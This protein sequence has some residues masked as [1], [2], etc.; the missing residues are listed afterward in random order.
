M[1]TSP[2]FIKLTASC[3]RIRAKYLATSLDELIQHDVEDFEKKKESGDP[4]VI[5]EEADETGNI[6]TTTTTTTTIIEKVVV[7]GS[8]ASRSPVITVD[9]SGP[10]VDVPTETTT[11]TTTSTNGAST[12]AAP[13]DPSDDP[14]VPDTVAEGPKNRRT[15]CEEKNDDDKEEMKGKILVDHDDPNAVYIGLRVYTHKDVPAVIVGRLKTPAVSST[16]P[17]AVAAPTT[18]V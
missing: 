13:N 11:T 4:V 1:C 16:T 18:P 10:V 2:F 8:A 15:R 5:K 7:R 3:F 9:E 6:F 17:A 12:P 14:N